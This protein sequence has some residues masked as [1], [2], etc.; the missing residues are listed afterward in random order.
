MKEVPVSFQNKERIAPVPTAP[1][2][3]F[4]ADQN[5][6]T[7]F[8]ED[9]HRER[10]EALREW[11]REHFE[12][13]YPKLHVN[14]FFSECE[15]LGLMPI[16]KMEG[17]RGEE[18]DQKRILEE[19]LSRR[20][21]SV[22]ALRKQM[23]PRPKPRMERGAASVFFEELITFTIAKEQ[24][25]SDSLEQFGS[26][27]ESTISRTLGGTWKNSGLT[28][29]EEILLSTRSAESSLLRKH[30]FPSL[31]YEA[32]ARLGEAE[33]REV[34][35]IA[36][37]LAREVPGAAL[38]LIRTFPALA[39]AVAF[40]ENKQQSLDHID[41]ILR[42][43]AESD[44]AVVRFA[45]LHVAD[46]LA[47]TAEARRAY[48]PIERVKEMVMTPEKKRGTDRL[49]R[50]ILGNISGTDDD[51]TVARIASDAIAFRDP[52]SSVRTAC[53]IPAE[54][55]D[56][57]EGID[58]GRDWKSIGIIRKTLESDRRGRLTRK[59]TGRV[60]SDLAKYL[61]DDGA[62]ADTER[63][64][65]A[66]SS[67]S[68]ALTRPE[69]KVFLDDT[70][71]IRDCHAMIRKERGRVDD[72]YD[73]EEKLRR[74]DVFAQVIA[75]AETKLSRHQDI[76]NSATELAGKLRESL[77]TDDIESGIE[78]LEQWMEET[79]NVD[80]SFRR[81]VSEKL[82][83][84]WKANADSIK[85]EFRDKQEAEA[86]VRTSF[87][88]A[89]IEKREK[90]TLGR[91]AEETSGFRN[92]ALAYVQACMDQAKSEKALLLVKP[93][94]YE[95]LLSRPELTPFRKPNADDIKLLQN[96]HAPE[97]ADLLGM[98]FTRLP[99][100]AQIHFLSFRGKEQ[101]A[102]AER[103]RLAL[104]KHEDIADDL[105]YSFLATAESSE[106]GETILSLA[107]RLD[108]D[109]LGPILKK[110][111]D[112]TKD[113]DAVTDYMRTEFP[114][115][116]QETLRKASGDIAANLLR[117]GRALLVEFSATAGVD[118]NGLL[119]K[120]ERIQVGTEL[121]K[122][123]LSTLSQKGEMPDLS[124]IA[125][126]ELASIAAE[127]LTQTEKSEMRDLYDQ[128]Y[129]ASKGYSE[130]FRRH[131]LE[132]L[133]EAFEKMGVR[134]YL[135]KRDG[136]IDGYI[137]FEDIG[138]TE[139]GRIRK[140]FGSFNMKTGLQHLKLGNALFDKC[141]EKEGADAVLEAVADTSLPISA[142]YL[143]KRGFIATGVEQVVDRLYFNIR[144]DP[145]MNDTLITKRLR[146]D[147]AIAEQLRSKG[148]PRG[149]IK[150]ERHTRN[151]MGTVSQDLL[152]NNWVLTHTLPVPDN[153]GD[154]TAVFEHPRPRKDRPVEDRAIAT[155]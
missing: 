71:R 145:K 43:M 147:G 69:W 116:P 82:R 41:T 115:I 67:I 99:L 103:F 89:D 87:D 120:L 148:S 88:I 135:L 60:I 122:E 33:E 86:A 78:Y 100:R 118:Q 139:D 11:V 73:T 149:Y 129:P 18:H 109:T 29:S 72:R 4:S 114:H 134:F 31:A 150:S 20:A 50:T 76:P 17:I 101:T 1:D 14:D 10:L 47:P 28:I 66:F 38:S 65:Q 80:D 137:R 27:I 26:N 113:T 45:A 34:T 107:E 12:E 105:A 5:G 64:S 32:T 8:T 62:L 102:D 13:Q 84:F 96:L 70:A 123:A 9:E 111:A 59:E 3:D 22:E 48:R 128:N 141:F 154:V 52:D 151:D 125:S 94:S 155:S 40:D 81:T 21:I 24:S 39:E 51:S 146:V 36:T 138:K 57:L 54:T 152:K 93:E 121:F 6:A 131:I 30:L 56:R 15:R 25:G 153:S 37:S 61:F 83:S 98:D 140:Y 58:S 108:T 63:L 16:R 117:E 136:H 110:Y 132:S 53:I 19:A 144:L 46:S 49:T 55:L 124:E 126:I 35:F 142:Y 23:T 42:T 97:G 2:R 143:E 85:A 127:D 106:Y 79:K 92:D 91:L 90:A 75:E 130:E 68:G 77:T 104:G 44:I 7:P 133:D 74:K 112:I 95:T 119:C